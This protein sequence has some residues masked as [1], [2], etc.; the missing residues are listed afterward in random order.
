MKK[1]IILIDLQ[2]DYVSPGGKMDQF[3]LGVKQIQSTLPRIKNFVNAVREKDVPLVHFQMTE[4]E[5]HVHP[6][7][8]KRRIAEFATPDNWSLATPGTWGHELILQP[9]EGELVFQKNT[10]DIFS[11]PKFQAFLEKEGINH[12][13]VL[14]G[15]ANVCVNAS[16]RSAV[17]K[18]HSVTL[19]TDLVVTPDVLQDKRASVLNSL[20]KIASGRLSTEI[21]RDL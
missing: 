16:V 17:A 5:H 19:A 7:L 11:N 2:N 21:L 3:G 9:K 20:T 4:D 18:G 15:Y 1:A 14:G 8:K 13:V 6:D 10:E 12:L